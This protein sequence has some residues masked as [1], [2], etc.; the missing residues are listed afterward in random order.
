L[1]ARKLIGEPTGT[2]AQC[3]ED[4]QNDNA[5]GK[6]PICKSTQSWMTAMGEAVMDEEE[7]QCFFPDFQPLR[8]HSMHIPCG[9]WYWHKIDVIRYPW[10]DFARSSELEYVNAHAYHVVDGIMEFK[11]HLLGKLGLI[12]TMVAKHGPYA[13][14]ITPVI[15]YW[16]MYEILLPTF[17]CL[18]QAL[19]W[20]SDVDDTRLLHP[21]LAW[22]A[23]QALADSNTIEIGKSYGLFQHE[24]WKKKLRVISQYVHRMDIAWVEADTCGL[25]AGM[26]TAVIECHTE[27]AFPGQGP[28]VYTVVLVLGCILTALRGRDVSCRSDLRDARI[29]TTPPRAAPGTPDR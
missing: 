10:G 13:F 28:N 20:P 8:H 7:T 9:R 26:T 5:P 3:S 11:F 24:A 4:R 27:E 21:C 23:L 1:N 19:Q 16:S 12:A 18:M 15:T 17:Y 22:P 25:E 29:P 6:N 14:G 2:L